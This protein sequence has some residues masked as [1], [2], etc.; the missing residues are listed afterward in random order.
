MK[1]EPTKLAMR[2]ILETQDLFQNNK[3]Y[4]KEK[5]EKESHNLYAT[6]P[7]GKNAIDCVHP[8]CIIAFGQSC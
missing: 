3:E 7:T 6:S 8:L 2:K 4:I 1:N 5:S